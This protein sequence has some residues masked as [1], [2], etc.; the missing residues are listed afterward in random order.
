MRDLILPRSVVLPH[1]HPRPRPVKTAPMARTK[2]R[3][4]SRLQRLTGWAAAVASR[5]LLMLTLSWARRGDISPAEARVL[6]Y[7][8]SA[9]Q[10]R[11]LH[12]LTLRGPAE[13]PS[14]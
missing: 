10:R 12:S 4:R 3:R 7:V 9:L 5:R 2:T 6:L 11:A 14:R 13:P 8:A 1:L